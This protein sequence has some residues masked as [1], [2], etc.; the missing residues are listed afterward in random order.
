MLK[1]TASLVLNNFFS[2]LFV[3]INFTL[4]CPEDLEIQEETTGNF[5]GRRLFNFLF[6]EYFQN[7][8]ELVS[9]PQN[10]YHSK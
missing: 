5:S 7:F 2:Q 8:M 10:S 1:V 4:A 6:E 9:G 3:R